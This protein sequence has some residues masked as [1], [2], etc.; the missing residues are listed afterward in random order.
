MHILK[1]K[2]KKWEVQKLCASFK[3]ISSRAKNECVMQYTTQQGY[4]MS[5]LRSR[6]L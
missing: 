4:G 1:K 2:I 3:V 5:L 6:S